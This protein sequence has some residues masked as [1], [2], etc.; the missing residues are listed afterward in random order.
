[1]LSQYHGLCLLVLS[2]TAKLPKRTWICL[3]IS[4]AGLLSLSSV[5]L[6]SLHSRLLPC[7]SQTPIGYIQ[8]TKHISYFWIPQDVAG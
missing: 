1:M 5:P 6:K 2:N 4:T 8:G 7:L 3:V